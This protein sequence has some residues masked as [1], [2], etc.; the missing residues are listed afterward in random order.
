MSVFEGAFAQWAYLITYNTLSA[1]LWLSLLTTTALTTALASSPAT[2]YPT[3]RLAVLTLQTLATLEILHAL[4]RLVH[5]PVLTTAVQVAGR[6]TV[7]YL[8]IEPYPT[9]ATASWW[10]AAMVLA[11]SA[12]DVV[13]YCYFATRLVGGHQYRRLAWL[14]YSAFYV[15]YPVGI[16]S[17]VGVVYGAVAE[18]WRLGERGHAWAYMAAAT[19]YLPGKGVLASLCLCLCLALWNALY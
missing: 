15:L 13:R 14:R 1:L 5:A 9:A 11:W 7:L 10:Y 19:L 12:A 16:A 6:L 17:E 2:V 4:T 8:V 3:L 18:A